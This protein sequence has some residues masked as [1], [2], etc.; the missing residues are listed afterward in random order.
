MKKQQKIKKIIFDPALF[1]VAISVVLIMVVFANFGVIDVSPIFKILTGVLV[2]IGVLLK[3]MIPDFLKDFLEKENNN[4]KEIED[5]ITFRIKVLEERIEDIYETTL[6]VQAAIEQ[7]YID[8]YL[9]EERIN[10]KQIE[11]I[12]NNLLEI[13]KFV[14]EVKTYL[15]ILKEINFIKYINFENQDSTLLD[16]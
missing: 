16:D 11:D 10:T 3:E 13:E 7:S 8:E 15:P 5:K 6:K 14:I 1:I 12:K 9:E 4:V 2:Y